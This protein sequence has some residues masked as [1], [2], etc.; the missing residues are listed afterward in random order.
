[1]YVACNIVMVSS[2]DRSNRIFAMPGEKFQ[3]VPLSRKGEKLGIDFPVIFSL[4]STCLISTN[5]CIC[6][7]V[8]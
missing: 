5:I 4:S 8:F 7:C 2:Q 3:N 6:V 1:M